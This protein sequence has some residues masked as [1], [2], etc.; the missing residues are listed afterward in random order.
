MPTVKLNYF[1]LLTILVFSL[2]CVSN[3]EMTVSPFGMSLLIEEEDEIIR[4]LILTNNGD[5][6]VEFKTDT[7][8]VENDEEERQGP[9][10]D[11]L[12]G[13][14]DRSIRRHS[15]SLDWI[16]MGWRINLGDVYTKL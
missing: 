14:S 11:D 12:G 15:N 3:A 13:R 1:A 16:S 4:D 10:R 8:L 9:L 2:V 5:T 7:W 6:E